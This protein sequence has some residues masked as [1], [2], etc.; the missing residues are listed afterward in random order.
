M[1]GD[2]RIYS[3]R[4]EGEKSPHGHVEQNP[5]LVAGS[6]HI[7]VSASVKAGGKIAL[8]IIRVGSLA[9]SKKGEDRKVIGSP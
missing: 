2:V 9:V 6:S 8:V 4:D 1:E 7:D 5:H 3:Y